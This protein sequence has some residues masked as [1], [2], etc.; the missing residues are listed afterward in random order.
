MTAEQEAKLAA[1]F[2][3]FARHVANTA[4]TSY[5]ERK[6]IEAHRRFDVAPK[7]G[8]EKWLLSVA[9]AGPAGI[10]MADAYSG[11]FA[12]NSVLRSKLVVTLAILECTPPSYA[13][14]DRADRSIGAA[15]AS[16]MFRGV[17]SGL[18]LLLGALIFA[19]PQLWSVATKAK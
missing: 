14:L 3:L 19:G 8:F 4:A 17:E 2:R 5:Q 6:Y 12:R 16:M 13:K 9:L 7:I 15:L 11:L 10:W 18:G 1:E